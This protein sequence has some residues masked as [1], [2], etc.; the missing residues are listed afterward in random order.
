[1]ALALNFADAFVWI[2]NDG[3]QH[4]QHSKLTLVPA[5]SHTHKFQNDN[6]IRYLKSLRGFE[7]QR[8]TGEGAGEAC[9]M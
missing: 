8:K 2:E 9:P 5:H 6:T 1:M 7:W 4:Q 3:L